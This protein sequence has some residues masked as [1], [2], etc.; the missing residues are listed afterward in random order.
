MKKL[1][2]IFILLISSTALAQE[3]N[4]KQIISVLITQRN[5]AMDKA[6]IAEVKVITL[7]D[8]LA[9]A[10][11]KIQELEEKLKDKK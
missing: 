8:D 7:K 5:E 1:V 10:K 6:A 11:T 3:N 4:D 9:K 2:L